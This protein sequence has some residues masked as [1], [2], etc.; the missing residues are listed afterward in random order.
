MRFISFV[1]ALALSSAS[2]V[3]ATPTPTEGSDFEV[4]IQMPNMITLADVDPSRMAQLA[5]LEAP[6]TNAERIKRGQ[7]L[8]PPKRRSNLVKPDVEPRIQGDD[9]IHLNS[10]RRAEGTK[11]RQRR[12]NP[13]NPSSKPG[14]AFT[15]TGNK[16]FAVCCQNVPAGGASGSNCFFTFASYNT[17][18]W[19]VICEAIKYSRGPV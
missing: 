10:E 13:N 12:Q 15:C 4:E 3:V 17:Q 19:Y 9:I 5:S 6:T 2:F 18:T 16:P 14:L 8:I 7:K 11:T 1:L